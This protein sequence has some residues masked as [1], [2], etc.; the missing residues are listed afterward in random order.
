MEQLE[1]TEYQLLKIGFLKK[2]HPAT[3]KPGIEKDTYDFTHKKITYEIPCINGCFYY[4]YNL[5]ETTYRWY[6]EID[7]GKGSNYIHLEIPNVPTL[8]T[9]LSAFRVKYNFFII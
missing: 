9:L 8:F 7:I 5:N 3:L 6:Q 1:L 2:V 4:N